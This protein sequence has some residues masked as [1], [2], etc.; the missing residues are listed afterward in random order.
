MQVGEG[1]VF[2][3]FAKSFTNLLW[4][5][6]FSCFFLLILLNLQKLKSRNFELLDN[7]V[8]R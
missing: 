6:K 8:D 2:I 3:Q 1:W 4:L 5:S 7:M